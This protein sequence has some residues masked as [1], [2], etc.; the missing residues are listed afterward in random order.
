M[1]RGPKKHMK[2]LGAP[3]SWML[4]KLG[5]I[6]APRPSPGPHKLRECLPLIILI[7]NRLKFALNGNE[8]Q[9]ILMQRLCKVDGKVRT[10]VTYP[11]GFMDVISF[12][13]IQ[14]HYRLLYDVKGRFKLVPIKADE[15]KFKLCKVTRNQLGAKSIPYI[16]TSDSRTM[17]FPDP[18][19]K[20]HDSV[21]VDLST[22][23]VQEFFKFEVGNVAMVTGGHNIG[24]VGVIERR[25]RHPGSYE[26]IHIK[27][28]NGHSFATRIENV[29]VIGNGS[30]PEVTLPAAKGIKK[31]ILE[32]ANL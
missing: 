32:E 19:I 12:D 28:T 7:R 8:V 26:I 14:Q 31:S 17:R 22:G 6:Y 13:S 2:R 25:E 15:A 30:N 10:D 20:I 21:K 3:K 1:G 27:D 11:S 29:F 4:D 16:A 5:G 18:D 24:R 9:T 23:K